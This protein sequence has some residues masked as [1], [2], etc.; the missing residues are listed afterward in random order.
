[1]KKRITPISL[2]KAV[3]GYLLWA[4]S[5][6]L[7]QNTINEY[8]V[9]FNHLMQTIDAGTPFNTI[10]PLDVEAFM[11]RMRD[12]PITRTKGVT[13]QYAQDD[14]EQFKRS[15]KTLRNYHAGLSS[16]WR[17][18]AEHGFATHNIMRQVTPP[19]VHKAP[20]IPLTAKQAKQLLRA[21]NESKRWHNKPKVTN[22][23]I[24]AARDKAIIS[25]FL[26]TGIRNSELCDLRVRDVTFYEGGGEVYIHEGKGNKSR[27]CPFGRRCAN[28]LNLWLLTRPDEYDETS[29]LFVNVVRNVG[30]SM[31]YKVVSRLVKRLGERAGIQVN[32]HKLRTTAAC[33]ML[34]NGMS[35][36][37]LQRILG[38]ANIET[39]MRYV[40]AAQ[41]DLRKAIR[42][43][44]PMDNIRL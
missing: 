12:S 23:R 11:R 38:H 27:Y 33:M 2:E 44:S 35:A 29:P 20:I 31:Q 5:A 26:D 3:N 24:T 32:P 6:G 8:R 15:P 16:L 22:A 39:T 9:T 4:H 34:Q 10:T 14:D 1:M 18:A 40:Q 42:K 7:S 43:A 19:K 30:T 25:L 17:W 41:V 28:H 36:F 21:C 37:E 13:A